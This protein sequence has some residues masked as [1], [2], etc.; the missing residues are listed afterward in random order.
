MHSVRA[1]LRHPSALT[2][3]HLARAGLPL[4]EG[5]LL[6]NGHRVAEIDAGGAVRLH[7]V[8]ADQSPL[9]VQVD[10]T[11]RWVQDDQPD[12]RA[13][14]HPGDRGTW[15][16]LLDRLGARVGLDT[17]AGA[18]WVRA[19]EGWALRTATGAWSLPD[20]AGPAPSDDLEAL[21]LALAVT[22]APQAS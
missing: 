8:R 17:T 6:L 10:G 9:L 5:M 11:W 19:P 16:L 18:L 14:P 13:L 7:D 20:T 21:A 22:H 2:V 3:Q 1:R 4:T 15:M 12:P